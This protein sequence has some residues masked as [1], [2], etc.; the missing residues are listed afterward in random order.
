MIC[1]FMIISKYYLTN[2]NSEKYLRSLKVSKEGYSTVN[3]NNI[4]RSVIQKLIKYYNNTE[5][6][7]RKTIK[8]ITLLVN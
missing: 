2:N 4:N 7:R 3:L 1:R 5:L 6:I 8:L